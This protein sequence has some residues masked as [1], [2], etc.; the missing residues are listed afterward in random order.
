MLEASASSY[1]F[2]STMLNRRTLLLAA[3]GVTAAHA[4]FARAGAP[5]LLLAEVYRPGMSLDD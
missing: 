5:S 1:S 3:L 2:H 4:A